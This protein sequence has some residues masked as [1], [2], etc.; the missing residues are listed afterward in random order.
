MK[1][2]VMLQ[3]LLFVPSPSPFGTAPSL[4]G[5]TILL[6]PE[7]GFGD[8]LQFIR[9][10]PLVKQNGGR[11]VFECP[12]ELVRI[13]RSCPGIDQILTPG[14]PLPPFDVQASLLSLPTILKTSLDTVPAAVPYLTADSSLTE[15]WRQE[16]SNYPGFK[17]GIVWQGNPR[18]AQPGCRA[19]DRKRSIPL[20]RFEALARLPRV[21]LFKGSDKTY[22]AKGN[23]SCSRRKHMTLAANVVQASW[24]SISRS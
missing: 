21:R 2:A 8:T 19:S 11:V 4:N 20:A 13:M 17:I 16:L 15:K 3:D 5:K 6:F 18:F 7:Q 12:A 9:Y 1:A 10:A 14:D 24:I 23:S 22:A